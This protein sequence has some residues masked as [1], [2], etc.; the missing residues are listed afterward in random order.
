MDLTEFHM[1]SLT[2]QL[3]LEKKERLCPSPCMHTAS[4]WGEGTFCLDREFSKNAPY[5]QKII[6]HLASSDKMEQK[7]FFLLGRW[8]G[9]N[10][11]DFGIPFSRGRIL[12]KQSFIVCFVPG[13]Q[14]KSLV[15]KI[16]TP[17]I[18]LCCTLTKFL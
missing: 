4:I 14:S 10:Q 9:G 3:A 6:F 2:V 11:N 18:N 8:I 13:E 1:I 12:E 16:C 7:N 15:V 5:K 17:M